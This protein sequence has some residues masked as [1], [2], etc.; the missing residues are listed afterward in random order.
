MFK[1]FKGRIKNI[2]FGIKRQKIPSKTVVLIRKRPLISFFLSFGVL[3]LLIVLGNLLKA[4]A[5]ETPELN[6]V[7]DVTVLS[8]GFP[9]V[10][11]S[12]QVRKYGILQISAQSTGIVSKVSVSEGDLVKKGK[13]LVSLSSNYQ[14]G[15][16]PSV[17]RQIAQKQYENTRDSF[18]SQK[19]I[20]NRQKEIAE[21]TSTQTEE[22]RKIA[23]KS[24]EDS[25]NLLNLNQEILN[26]VNDNLTN[27]EQNNQGG[28]NDALI[29]QTKQTRAAL[30]QSVN[31]LKVSIR[32]A[33]F[34][35][36][37][38]NTPTKLSN[39]NK[40]ITLKQLEYQEKTLVLNKEVSKLQL[41]LAAISEAF[42][43]PVSPCNGIVQKVNVAVS[44]Q[45][46]P[47]NP[48]IIVACDG[49]G[50]KM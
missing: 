47:G 9:S 50:V 7:K 1:K 28:V 31:L 38:D 3:L 4:P 46:N 41:S 18:D 8:L 37:T 45:V 26:K 27:L 11:V 23:E 17:S 14:G 48:M 29:L 34:S 15:I 40:D 30:Q 22:L 32:S 25:N 2:F 33:D 43:F 49:R 20:I 10:N 39:L 13:N 35:N 44:E 19:D 5:R 24:N 16:A 21:Q 6:I 42:M 12:G 36:N